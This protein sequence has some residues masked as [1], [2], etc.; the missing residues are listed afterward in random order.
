MGIFSKRSSNQLPM[1]RVPHFIDGKISYGTSTSASEVFDPSK[2]EIIRTVGVANTADVAE[3]V[4]AAERAFPA[5]A[6]LPA[7]NRANF[8]SAFRDRLIRYKDVLA[9]T[10][11]EE[12]GKTLPN[13]HAELV[14]GIQMVEFAASAA[15]TIQEASPTKKKDGIESWSSR[16]PLGVCVGITP[17]NFPAMVPLWMF[18]IAIATGNTFVLK[19]SEKVPSL[20]V[21]LAEL[22]NDAGVPPG[23]LNVV[24]GKAETTRALIA[25]PGVQAVSFV[26]ST[27]VAKHIYELASSHHLRVQALGSAKNHLVVMP[28]AAIDEVCDRLIGAAYGSAGERCMAVAVAVV[29]GDIADTFVSSLAERVRGITVG[30]ALTEKKGIGPLITR[31]HLDRTRRYIADGVQEGAQLLVDGRRTKVAGH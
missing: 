27:P 21:R 5:W 14:R 26:G 7:I 8:L 1:V 4:Q 23:V 31:E 24:H 11:S 22:L 19:P 18:P 20:P 12:V 15:T 9:A 17:F 30:P 3:A 6:A 13:A 29:V 16:E 25:Q 10:I 28:D 2:G